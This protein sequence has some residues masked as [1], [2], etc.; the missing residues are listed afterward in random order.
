MNWQSGGGLAHRLL[1]LSTNGT[2]MAS[3]WAVDRQEIESRCHG[4]EY[5]N[6]LTQGRRGV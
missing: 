3:G 6:S 5:D 1:R 4:G 2:G